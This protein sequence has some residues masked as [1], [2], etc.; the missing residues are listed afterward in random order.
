MSYVVFYKRLCAFSLSLKNETDVTARALCEPRRRLVVVVSFAAG[1]MLHFFLSFSLSLSISLFSK[2]ARGRFA[3]YANARLFLH[4][5]GAPGGA[6]GGGGLGGGGP[7][8]GALGGGGRFKPGTAA[9]LA[10]AVAVVVA[11][12][13]TPRV[14]PIPPPCVAATACWCAA[15]MASCAYS[16]FVT[17][18][19]VSR[20]TSPGL[21]RHQ[22]LMA[23]S[24][25]PETSK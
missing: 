24:L 16:A 12:P 4:S 20:A 9:P 6:L 18:E 21:F 17:R 19:V 25:L 15:T 1:I 5:R 23:L 3:K 22:N 14:L 2:R 7:P 11:L 10:D 8:G 13:N